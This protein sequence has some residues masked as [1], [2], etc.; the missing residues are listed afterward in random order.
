MA[1]FGGGKKR[2][3]ERADFFVNRARKEG[4]FNP[5]P[6]EIQQKTARAEA[7]E[8]SRTEDQAMFDAGVSQRT[9]QNAQTREEGIA[10]GRIRGEEFMGRDFRGMTPREKT[11]MEEGTQRKINRQMQGHQRQLVGQQGG[12]GIRGGA[13]YAQQAD[14]ARVGMEQQRESLR[15]INQMDSDIA[16]K[17][18]AAQF[19]IEY[20]EGAQ[21]LYD[22]QRA[23]DQ[24]TM[25]GEEKK[26]KR[27]ENQF[28]N[29]YA[30][31]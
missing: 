21:S 8:A 30:R 10:K 7:G 12:R 5:T 24:L 29:T 27:Y 16:M 31:V 13:A 25:K 22:R 6:Q 28:Y 1:L 4:Y 20:G 26:G 2:S 17:K 9:Q 23:E 11:S 14:L 15:D 3:K 18:R 19:A